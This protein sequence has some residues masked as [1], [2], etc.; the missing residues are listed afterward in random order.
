MQIKNRIIFI[1]RYKIDLLFD[2]ILY[3]IIIIGYNYL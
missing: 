2:R 3:N 1:S